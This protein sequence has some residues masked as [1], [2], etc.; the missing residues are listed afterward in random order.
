MTTASFTIRKGG[1]PILISAPHAYA[2]K[3]PQLSGAYKVGELW[4][5]Y[6]CEQ[7][8]LSLNAWGIFTNDLIDYDPNFNPV[9]RNPYKQAITD[10]MRENKIMYFLD[11]H[12]LSPKHEYDLGYYYAP[13][14][15][16]SRRMAEIISKDIDKN[17]LKGLNVKFLNFLDNEQE[18]LG[19]YVVSNYKIPSVQ[20]EIAKYI[21]VTPELRE[22]FLENMKTTLLTL[23]IQ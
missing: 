10:I 17:A 7:L 4:T 8:S 9:E 12:G 13:R 11:L 3:R 23:P 16:N 2:H 15:S 21:R 19:E 18:T 5:D 20:L 6:L 14:Y 22:T 1:L